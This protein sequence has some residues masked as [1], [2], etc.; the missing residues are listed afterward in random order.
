MDGKIVTENQIGST[1]YIVTSECSQTASETL[2]K[3]LERLIL[4]HVSGTEGYQPKS[5]IQLAIYGDKS[6]YVST[7]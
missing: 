5:E 1:T 7:I 6:E 4:R 2:E 3:K